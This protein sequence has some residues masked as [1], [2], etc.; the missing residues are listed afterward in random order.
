M[1]SPPRVREKLI[2]R[3]LIENGHGITPACA[4]KNISE[5]VDKHP[6]TGSPPRV[7]EKPKFVKT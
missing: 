3:K 7:R 1:G 6:V 4:G 5:P 2:E